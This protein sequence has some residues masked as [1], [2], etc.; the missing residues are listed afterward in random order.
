MG[1]PSRE[2]NYKTLGVYPDDEAAKAALQG[3][4]YALASGAPLYRMTPASGQ[5]EIPAWSE[6]VKP[7]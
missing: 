4:L 1:T 6:A 7:C 3:L 5:D 2:F